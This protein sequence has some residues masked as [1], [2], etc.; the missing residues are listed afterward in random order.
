MVY[1]SGSFNDVITLLGICVLIILALRC[2]LV[3]A[4]PLFCY[5][6]SK[7]TDNCNPLE[8]ETNAEFNQIQVVG[9]QMQRMEEGEMKDG[10]IENEINKIPVATLVKM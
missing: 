3:F 8:T 7:V 5:I 2:L 4:Y 9:I 6:E 1:T 10:E